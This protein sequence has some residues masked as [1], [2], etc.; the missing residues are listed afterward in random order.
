[1]ARFGS[2]WIPWGDDQANV[3]AGIA[4]LRAGLEQAGR[5][6]AGLKVAGIVKVE[7]D[8]DG[9]L[10]AEKTMAAVPALVAGGVTDARLRVALPD[11]E[12]EARDLVRRI[13]GAFRSAV[14]RTDP[15]A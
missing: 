9:N 8:A 3:L 5:D 13:A 14:G 15:V 10:D 4:A 7:R 11:D 12:S 1:V 2:G 6:P